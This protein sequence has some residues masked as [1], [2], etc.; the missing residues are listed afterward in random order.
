M[1]FQT[2]D[3]CVMLLIETIRANFMKLTFLSFFFFLETFRQIANTQLQKPGGSWC[4]R[5][6][7]EEEEKREK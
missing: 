1:T 3:D 7:E 6:D 2:F 5:R 4:C